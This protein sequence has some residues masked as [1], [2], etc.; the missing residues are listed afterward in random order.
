MILSPT[1]NGYRSTE[2][3]VECN[4]TNSLPSLTI[5]GLASKSVDESKERIRA[6][7]TASGYKFPKKRIVINLAPADIP[8]N[9]SSLD[10]AMAIAILISD[11][12][13]Q[14]GQSKRIA[15][16]GE[17]GLDG[18]VRPVRG[19]IGLLKDVKSTNDTIVIV[20]KGNTNQVTHFA[21][22][23]KIFAIEDI[24][25]TVEFLNNNRNL[26]QIATV[27]STHTVEPENYI[28]FAE[29]K[30][31]D[32]AKRALLIAASGGHSILLSGPPGTG[33][34]MLA[35]A[36]TGILPPLSVPQSLETTHIHSLAGFELYDL[37]KY[38]PLRSPHH[39]A[40][41][42]AII[43]GGHTLKPGEISLA[44]NGVLF[45]DELPEFQKPALE[46]LR[47]PLEDNKVSITRAQSS[48]TYPA[49]FILIATSN[50]CPCGYYGSSK[51][52]HCTA[53]E[54]NRYQ[55]KLSGP[56][57]DRIDIHIS[58]NDVHHKSLLQ[59]SG[60]KES[61]GLREVVIKARGGQILRGK[62]LNANLSNSK[63]RQYAKFEDGTKEL[64]DSA[65]QKMDISARSY[66]KTIKIARTI[67]DIEGSDSIKKMH[68]AEAL[69][70]RPKQ[71]QTL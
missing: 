32:N 52:C 67:A 22:R 56:I 3:T 41:N 2:V 19:I 36:F 43:G 1:V 13:I 40:S 29:I 51:T 68:I 47:Q 20:P 34:S 26:K 54:I 42:V 11:K 15:C 14:I 16:I 33:K 17:L 31:Q 70:F 45:L 24:R 21:D 4:L 63:L 23:L 30:G 25:Q 66:I 37:I 59:E 38:P 48:A 35:K 69:Q 65:A 5:V 49:N 62:H 7:I 50:P 28:D 58:V 9:S 8:K 10:L 44:H 61:P 27:S 6:A 53:Q 55:K 39:T 71:L 46:S 57:M 12:Q 18:K 60:V 64:L